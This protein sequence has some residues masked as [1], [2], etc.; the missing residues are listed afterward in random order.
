MVGLDLAHPFDHVL[1]FAFRTAAQRRAPLTAVHVWSPPAGTEYMAFGAIG[2][3]EKEA[4]EL[5]K[6][7][8]D[9]ALAPWL[10]RYP[11]LAVTARP[12]RGHAHVT[13]IDA[14]AG[15]G[16]LVVGARH[17]GRAPLAAR[18]GSV[19]HAVLHHVRCPVAVVPS[20]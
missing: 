7:R 9:E 19:T 20:P 3:W 12:L 11:D 8:L 5:E 4:A 1:D 2:G 14:T 15:A 17:R 10:K 13:L 6:G 18:L 16:L